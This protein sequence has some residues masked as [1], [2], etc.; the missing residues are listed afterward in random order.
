MVVAATTAEAGIVAAAT[1]AV[2]RSPRTTF[3][4][5]SRRSAKSA[6]DERWQQQEVEG[7]RERDERISAH[8]AY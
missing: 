6:G 3:E 2:A 5:A 4:L 8:R 1:V 7:R